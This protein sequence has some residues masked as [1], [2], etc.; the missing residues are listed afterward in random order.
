M[1]CYYCNACDWKTQSKDK[2][3]N[4][5]D[6][7]MQV[8]NADGYWVEDDN[9]EKKNIATPATTDNKIIIIKLKQERKDNED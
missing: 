6:S 4:H 5:L 1:G 7:Y 9:P 2:M 3:Q 8:G